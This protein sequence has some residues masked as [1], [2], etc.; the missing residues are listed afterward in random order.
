MKKITIILSSI[1]TL[2]SCE[3]SDEYQIVNIDD[4]Y[5]LTIPSFLTKVNN[6][7]DNA[8]LQYQHG[9]KEF[10]VIVIDESKIELQNALEDY[11]L[12]EYFTND[13]KGYSDLLLE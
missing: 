4:K 9:L 6:L 2:N 13:V 11:Q 10:Y 8:S 1:L 5:S 7:N 3:P 12:T